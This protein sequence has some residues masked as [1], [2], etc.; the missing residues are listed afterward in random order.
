MI[1]A[2]FGTIAVV[3]AGI[4]VWQWIAAGRFPLHRRQ[5]NKA[6]PGRSPAISGGGV[7]LLKPL[8]G[9]DGETRACLESWVAQ[10]YGGP[11]Q[12][13]FGV[14]DANDPVCEIVRELQKNFP[15]RASELVICDPILGAN[16]KVSTLT[17]L[18]KK[19]EHPFW[20]VSDA[21]VLAPADLV[22][23]IVRKFEPAEV[24]LVN[25]FY[26]LP[27]AQT[28][29]MIWENIGVNAD[30][31]SQVCQSN[32][33]KPMNFA[34]GAV[35]AV[36]R[37]AVEMIGGFKPLL[38]QLAD[39]YQLGRRLADSGKRIELCNVVVECREAR[40]GFVAVW[41]HQ[42]RWARTIRVCQPRPYF[43]SILSNTTIWAALWMIVSPNTVIAPLCLVVRTV[44][45]MHNE[46]RLTRR[47]AD[48][49]EPMFTF[50]KDVLQFLVWLCAFTGN[51]VVWRGKNFR[52]KRGGE[53]VAAGH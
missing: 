20:I 45:A 2:I 28:V 49:F 36:R 4:N 30:F 5:G 19:A 31:W 46:F 44:T 8:K 47:F 24:G 26:K 21:D 34:L 50:A 23:E 6:E 42:L 17:Y 37:G 53:L 13:L 15:H 43:A 9:A 14:A 3:S 16:A 29:A 18:E 1:A 25:C 35:M 39:D 51:S 52:V 27:P 7:T 40:K 12:I 38:N 32:S 48:A 41:K 11:M 22:S 10:D 33:M